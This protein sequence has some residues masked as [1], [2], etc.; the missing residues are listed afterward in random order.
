MKLA[1]ILVIAAFFSATAR[2]D[3]W[4]MFGRDYTRNA[5]SPEKNPPVDWQV[6]LRDSK[7]K[8]TQ[9]ARHIKWKA[10]VAGSVFTFGS[11]VVAGG[12]VWVCTTY[13]RPDDKRFDEPSGSLAC[14]DEATGKFRW[15]YLTSKLDKDD[16][17]VI[18]SVASPPLVEGDRLWFITNRWEIVCL[19]IG[20]L[21]K[22]SGEP[23]EV[24]KIDMRQDLKVAPHVTIMSPSLRCAIGASYKGMIYAITGNGRDRQW[25]H[26]KRIIPAPDAPSLICVDKNTG[27]VIWE[28]HSPGNDILEGQ[29]SSPLVAEI[30][31]RAQVIAPEGDGW[32]RSFDATTG[33]LIWKCDANPKGSSFPTTR[34]TI[35]AA[36]V[37]YEGRIYITPGEDLEFGIGQSTLWCIDPSKEG[38]VSEELDDGPLPSPGRP[39]GLV[40]GPRRGKPN[41]NSGVLWKFHKIKRLPGQK[42]DGTEEMGRTMSSVVAAEGL[43]IAAD[44]SG[45]VHCLDARTG[46]RYWVRDARSNMVTA[47]L[48][49]DGKIYVGGEEG[50]MLILALSREEKL[51]ATHDFEPRYGGICRSPI[52]ANGVLY[53]MTGDAL[54][55]IR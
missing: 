18:Y 31:G 49:C 2:A 32:V 30:N 9:P 1:G 39:P 28:D 48:I 41:P 51:L 46:Q 54:F 35:I 22:G 6:E 52:F 12:L 16:R 44:F 7:R 13:Y 10:E 47:P 26:E 14:L 36:P 53:V 11:P 33:K 19:D 24:W 5:A 34:C 25:P 27:R 8:I 42:E 40:G 43:V 45:L 23:K 17:G 50:E 38:D 20:P 37:L 21:L 4:P 3:D 15:Q 29:W 55:A